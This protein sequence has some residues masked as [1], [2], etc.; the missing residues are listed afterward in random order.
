MKKK[1]WL[2]WLFAFLA[3]A[4]VRIVTGVFEFVENEKSRYRGTAVAE[5]YDEVRAGQ[6]YADLQRELAGMTVI[7]S[8]NFGNVNVIGDS[9]I[10]G[11]FKEVTPETAGTEPSRFRR[12]GESLSPAQKETVMAWMAWLDNHMYNSD[13]PEALLLQEYVR[14]SERMLDEFIRSDFSDNE[15]A[16]QKWEEMPIVAWLYYG[17]V[18]T[19]DSN[20]CNNTIERMSTIYNNLQAMPEMRPVQDRWLSYDSYRRQELMNRALMLE[21][22]KKERAPIPYF[23]GVDH[24]DYHMENRAELIDRSMLIPKAEWDPLRLSLRSD[25]QTS[26]LRDRE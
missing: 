25:Y 26:V 15:E 21:S 11:G 10:S 4:S 16:L 9:M 3:F 20:R 2:L 19:L 8:V 18:I 22:E 12:P 24:F 5:F 17:L 7:D 13:A 14:V 23:C 6:P 1:R